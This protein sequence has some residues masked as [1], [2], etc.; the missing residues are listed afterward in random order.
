MSCR[1]AGACHNRGRPARQVGG[2]ALNF[3]SFSGWLLVHA[4]LVIST[5]AYFTW[6]NAM[7]KNPYNGLRLGL[8]YRPLNR[9]IFAPFGSVHGNGELHGFMRIK[10]CTQAYHM[11]SFFQFDG[12][13]DRE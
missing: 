11:V 7:P 3:T 12:F 4:W 13:Q 2:G 10:C 6:R 8:A 1:G 5:I 9:P